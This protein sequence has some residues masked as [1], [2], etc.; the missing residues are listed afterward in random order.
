MNQG[1]DCGVHPWEH[2]IGGVTVEPSVKSKPVPVPATA[3][4]RLTSVDGHAGEA[5]DVGET[6]A[7]VGFEEGLAACMASD[8]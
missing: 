6:F 7:G 4:V 2:A 1:D 8:S 3:Q 5:F